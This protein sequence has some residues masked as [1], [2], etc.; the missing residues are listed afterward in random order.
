MTKAETLLESLSGEETRWRANLSQ[1]ETL[2]RILDPLCLTTAYYLT[3]LLKLTENDREQQLVRFIA[4]L[5]RLE[6]GT[7]LEEYLQVP[8]RSKADI[9][10]K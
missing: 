9:R 4:I 6:T 8:L 1:I 3:F 2:K 7:E 10:E 5:V